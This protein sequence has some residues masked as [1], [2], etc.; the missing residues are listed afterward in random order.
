MSED[1]I[2]TAELVKALVLDQQTQLQLYGLYKQATQGDVSISEP[3]DMVGIMKYKSWL[4]NK[5]KPPTQAEEEYIALVK[6]F[7]ASNWGMAVSRPQFDEEEEETLN[8]YEKSVKDFCEAVKEENIDLD[9]LNTLGINCQDKQ[10]LT[11][12]HHAVDEGLSVVV[13]QLIN[14]GA[15]PN[16][17]D[18]EGMTPA[19]YAVELDNDEILEILL[20][21]PG[22]DL[23][24]EDS[25]GNTLSKI[26]Q[27][28][29]N[30]YPIFKI[31][32]NQYKYPYLISK[33]IP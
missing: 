2:K 1:F 30:F 19:H 21:A 3:K 12:L 20:T 22:I 28:N 23:T 15:N 10:G 24:I 18:S 17:Q 27:K 9:A 6:S 14:M 11:P 32:I 4:S 25:S 13:R 29:Y 33:F 5:G 31:Y 26:V 16:I 8:D 7:N